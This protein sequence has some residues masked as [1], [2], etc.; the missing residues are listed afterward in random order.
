MPTLQG[1]SNGMV[2]NLNAKAIRALLGAC[3]QSKHIGKPIEIF[4][5][6]KSCNNK[7]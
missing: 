7:K 2:N 5:F 1:K 3:I 4:D 6:I